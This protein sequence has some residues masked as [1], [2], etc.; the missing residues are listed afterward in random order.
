MSAA[1]TD[2]PKLPI[3]REVLAWARKHAGVSAEDAAKRAGVSNA[4][5][6]LEWEKADGTDTPTVR[7][8]RK[9]AELYDRKFLEF[10]RRSPPKPATPS[11]LADFRLY[12]GKDDP[13]NE[14][15]MVSI[16]LWAEAQRENALGLLAELGEQ[17]KEIPRHLFV[18]VDTDPEVHALAVRA[19]IDFPIEEQV[20]QNTATRQ[21][22]PSFL[23]QK[24]EQ[25]GTLTL[26]HPALTKL[27]CGL[28]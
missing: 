8:A 13:N 3:N 24:I 2:K 25:L 14:R 22:M 15:L 23:R 19:A 10:F 28:N 11:A 7:Q 9:L 12:A 1:T 26:R 17:T 27:G 21:G 4:E 5:R 6:V 16:R 18:R 20:G